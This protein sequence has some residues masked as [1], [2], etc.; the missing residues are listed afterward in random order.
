MSAFIEAY[1]EYLE[2][3]YDES[4]ELAIIDE[5]T[6]PLHVNYSNPILLEWGEVG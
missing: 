4:D 5:L 2:R 3:M 1:R 6:V